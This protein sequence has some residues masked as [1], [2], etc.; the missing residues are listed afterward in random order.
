MY[1]WHYPLFAFARIAD[2]NG[3]HNDEKYLLILLTIVLSI[4][5]YFVIEKPFRNKQFLNTKKFSIAILLLLIAVLGMNWKAI[6]ETNGFIERIPPIVKNVLFEKE[7][8]LN[9]NKLV[10]KF[11]FD[12]KTNKP[13]M[14]FLGDS[15]INNLAN[16]AQNNIE[17]YEVKNFTTAGCI[18]TLDF[19]LYRNLKNKNIDS[20]CNYQFQTKVFEYIEKHQNKGTKIIYGGMIPK[21]LSGHWY[22]SEGN[23]HIDPQT[24]STKWHATFVNEKNEKNLNESIM[25]TLRYLQ[26][27]GDVIFISPIIELAFNPLNKI[28][29]LNMKNIDNFQTLLS[30]NHSDF[31]QRIS[32][33]MNFIKKIEGLKIVDTEDIFCGKLKGRCITLDESEIYFI[34][35]IHLSRVGGRLI[36]NKML[37]DGFI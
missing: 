14:I 6:D 23:F 4:V 11:D 26:K 37:L 34:D 31:K 32:Y 29:K 8:L 28:L 13:K 5:S 22:E 3:L 7:K 35:K 24:R 2:T 16:Y 36:F 21:A 25:D 20:R 10:F 30:V 12:D 15:V 1:L 18:Y 17:N 27:N 19:Q 33:T 9:D